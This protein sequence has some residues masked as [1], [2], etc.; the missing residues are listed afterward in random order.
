[1]PKVSIVLPTYNGEKYLR[2]SI[3][4][5][6]NQTFTDW[7]LIIV[8]DCSTDSTPQISEE[9]A[10]KDSRIRVIHN[11]V[12]QKLP[13]S[14][15]IGFRQAKGE[16]LTWTSDDNLYLPEAIEKMQFF[17]CKNMD[18]GL[19]FTDMNY[20]DDSGMVISS[21]S[22]SCHKIN[23]CNCVG[24]SFMYRRDV[25][26]NV[27]EYDNSKILIEDYD[28]WIRVYS[29]YKVVRFP[30]V[31]YEYRFH[32][33]SMTSTRENE[34]QKKI[35]GLK[36]EYYDVL[37]ANLN[38]DELLMFGWGIVLNDSSLANSLFHKNSLFSDLCEKVVKMSNIDF[39]K[40]SIIIGVGVIGR[41]L[42]QLLG[43]ENVF[44]YADNFSIEKKIDG[45]DVL[46]VNEILDFQ[47]ECNIII[48]VGYM[49]AIEIMKQLENLG[50]QSFSVYQLLK[51][52]IVY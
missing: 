9:Y 40:K 39:K 11:E 16:F 3:D 41:K 14:L 29:K 26:D 23:L 46:R 43:S 45:K 37:T 10:I 42:F 22:R 1:M 31:L 30:E 20:I 32:G 8:N 35:A 19:V 5:V 27:G 50:V 52:K 49:N 6:I 51:D 33:N 4:S 47:D 34:I 2:E 48:A 18:V 17:L 44:C 7:E 24:A 15:N 12:N 21:N 36:V 38:E 28:Y 25:A 13:N